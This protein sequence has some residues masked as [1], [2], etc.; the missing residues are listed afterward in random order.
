[1]A[2]H[3]HYDIIKSLFLSFL[4]LISLFMAYDI[5][6][7]NDKIKIFIII[8]RH[9]MTSTR[10][11]NL[12]SDI[13][14]KYTVNVP[15][16]CAP[17]KFVSFFSFACFFSICIYF[18]AAQQTLCCIR[19]FILVN[20]MEN[21]VVGAIYILMPLFLLLLLL[22]LM[23]T[24]SVIWMKQHYDDIDIFFHVENSSITH[25]HQV[26]VSKIYLWT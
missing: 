16:I 1:M 19:H 22:L 13:T 14:Q 24:K 6:F 11:I 3:K 12:M 25:L 4:S 8:L 7:Q 21:F 26:T 23:M 2:G 9:K 10:R 17:H 18:H 5:N 20:L 15:Q